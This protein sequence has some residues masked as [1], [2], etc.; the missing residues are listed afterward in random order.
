MRFD[1]Q[2]MHSHDGDS[3]WPDSPKESEIGHAL[4][5]RKKHQFYEPRSYFLCIQ[6]FVV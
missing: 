5:T 3:D 1:L 2:N 6:N 4:R